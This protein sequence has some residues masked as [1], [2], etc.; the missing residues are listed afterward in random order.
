[1]GSLI[2]TAGDHQPGRA[3]QLQQQHRI[4]GLHLGL[5]EEVGL[6]RHRLQPGHWTVLRGSGTSSSIE[7]IPL[8]DQLSML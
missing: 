5:D 2:L 1:M 6:L 8:G 3:G 4:P 7:N